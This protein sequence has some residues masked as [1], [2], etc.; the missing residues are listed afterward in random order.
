MVQ[1]F[2]KLEAKGVCSF[3]S[4]MTAAASYDYSYYPLIASCPADANRCFRLEGYLFPDTYE[5]YIGERPQD[6]IG[7]MIRNAE[8][9][10]TAADRA[11]AG[12]MGYTV[13]QIITVASIIQKEGSKATEVANVAAVIYNR[14]KSGQKLQM[15]STINYIELYVKN[16]ISGDNTR[17]NSAY[18]TYKCAALP[19]GPICS[20]GKTT[21]SAA[22]HP[23]DVP[24][25]FFCHDASGN[26]YYATT[27]KE[28]LANLKLA[29]IL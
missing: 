7:R 8:S 21:I 6:A 24:Y 23:S 19:A 27:Y 3:D 11:K 10:I 2:K 5:F 18:N 9:K 17:Y 15:D 16:Y 26:Y 1:I 12:T 13:D 25:L 22:L 20:P 29:G 28:H 14:L 4:L